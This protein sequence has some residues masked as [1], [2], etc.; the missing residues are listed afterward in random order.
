[1]QFEE[2]IE[3]LQSTTT[4]EDI[5]CAVADIRD[6]FD[7]NHVVYHVVGHTGED[8]GALT[9]DPA[10]VDYY[11]SEERFRVDPVVQ[12]SLKRFHPVDWTSLDWSGKPQRQLMAEAREAGLGTQGLTVPIRGTQGKFALFSVTSN[13]AP[14]QWRSYKEEHMRE[15]LLMSHYIHHRSI[16]VLVGNEGYG[17]QE[18]SPREQD[19]LRLLAL[20]RSRAQA[21][22]TL[23]ISEHTFRVYVD[24]A[25][26]KLGAMNTVHAVSIALTGGHIYL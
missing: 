23:K 15:L 17:G 11:V 9:Y 26:H 13:A 4:L 16:E 8:F 6:H 1:M 21:S 18:L 5:Q 22:E 10:W 7:A 2:L 20:G 25:R 24:T 19:V 14:D 12:D 3:R